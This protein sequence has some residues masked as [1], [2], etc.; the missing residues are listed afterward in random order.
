MPPGEVPTLGNWFRA[1]GYDTHY[2]GKWHISHADLHD[3]DGRRVETNTAD[4][5]VH[6]FRRTGLSRRRP[7]RS[8][9]ASRDGSVPSRTARAWPTAGLRRDP[10]LADRLVAWLED[11]YARRAAGDAEALR[12]FLLVASFVNPHDIVLF[13]AWA[14]EAADQA[15]RAERARG[16]DPARGPVDQAGRADRLPRVLLLGLRPAAGDRAV[17]HEEG[18][19]LP[20]PLLPAARRGGRAARPGPQGGDRRLG[21]A[22][23]WSA[24]P[25]TASC[26]APTAVCT[27]SGSTSTTRPPGCRL[28]DRPH[29][30]DAAAHGRTTPDLARRHRPDAAVGRRARRAEARRSSW[31]GTSPRCTRCPGH[32]PDA[33]GRRRRPPTDRPVYLMTRDNMLEGD[34][35]L[36]GLA[37][38]LGRTAPPPAPLRIRVAAHVASG[39]EGVVA[40]GRTADLWKLVRTYDDPATWTEPGPAA[41]GGQR[42]RRAGVPHRAAA[43][44][45]GAL[46]PRRRPDRGGQPLA[47]PRPRSSPS[48]AASSRRSSSAASPNGTTPGP[49]PPADPEEPL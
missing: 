5:K 28:V 34:T 23:C 15:R 14:A 45:V 32:R 19:D 36:S 22:R 18:A 43:R 1:G 37:R 31:R 17:L 46:R 27:R 30:G 40:E 3:A 10:L 48:C 38:R 20:R 13:P 25:T 44:P 16:A 6:P 4:G 29:R 26:S 39:F 35:G 2:D 47:G 41:P 8:P 24:R 11:R 9:T 12:P 21:R 7:A 42:R 49:T 33:G